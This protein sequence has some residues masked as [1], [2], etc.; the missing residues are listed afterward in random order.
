[1]NLINWMFMKVG[2]LFVQL[3]KKQASQLSGVTYLELNLGL[4][5]FQDHLSQVKI[6]KLFMWKIVTIFLHIITYVLGA[7][8]NHLI[9]Y[10]ST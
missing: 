2:R 6:T 1:M 10:A 4:S 9:E 5:F 7:K 3:N 8:K